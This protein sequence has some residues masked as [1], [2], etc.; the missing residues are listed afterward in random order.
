MGKDYLITVHREHIAGFDAV[1]KKWEAKYRKR[2]IFW[3][4][5]RVIEEITQTYTDEI[6][7]ME[8]LMDELEAY[9]TT[10]LSNFMKFDVDC[11]RC[12]HCG[13]TIYCKAKM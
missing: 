8:S 7:R 11:P 9:L 3:L 1:E 2:P 5:N 10:I 6:T 4:V 12:C 13:T